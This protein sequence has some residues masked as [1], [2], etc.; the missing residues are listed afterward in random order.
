MQH[1]DTARK[2]V[3]KV[4]KERAG[5]LARKPEA[6]SAKGEAV[7]VVA[8]LLADQRLAVEM[9]YVREIRPLYPQMWSA[10]P[11]TP[12]HIVGAANI[13]GRIHSI[14]TVAPFLNQEV[15]PPSSAAHLIRIAG[16]GPD[17]PE[18]MTLCL[19]ADDRPDIETIEKADIEPM[20]AGSA[21][22]SMA[23]ILGSTGGL[24]TV[25]DAGSLLSSPKI[26]VDNKTLG[27]GAQT[28]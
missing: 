4:L 28:A 16:E 11:C 6:P 13:R 21:A 12:D 18:E 15:R 22:A 14:M 1:F 9:S 10:V 8:F 2:E 20:P 23:F 19:L 26:I 17:P 3:Q 24:L 27:G 25:L 7:D 5:K